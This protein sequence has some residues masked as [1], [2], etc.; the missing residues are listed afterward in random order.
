MRSFLPSPIREAAAALAVPRAG[1]ADSFVLHAPLELLARAGLLV[2]TSPEDRE[3]AL[4]QVRRLGTRFEAAGDPVEP[5]PRADPDPARLVAALRAGDLDEVDAQ[6]VALAAV[7]TAGELRELLGPV[8]LS[9]LAA[10]AHGAILLHL[11]RTVD[12]VGALPLQLIRQP[13]RELARNPTWQLRWF[14]DPDEPSVTR[15]LAE[16]LLDVPRL[17]L[18]GSDFIHPL[19]RQAEDSGVAPAL[20]RGV[21]SEAPA[22]E[23]DLARVAAWSMLQE[24]DEHV[25]YGW[26]HCL[27]MPQAAVRLADVDTRAVAVAATYVVGFRAGEGQ[28]DLDPAAVPPAPISAAELAGYAGSHE[29]AHLAK[30]ALASL[31]AAA[32]D[33]EMRHLHLAAA[34]RLVAWWRTR[35]QGPST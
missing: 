8:V 34:G 29:D 23:R 30:Y 2:H 9:S 21:R 12:P 3:A 31:Q 18:P 32:H 1:P 35:G 7:A 4:E 24:P 28:I 22:A 15:A 13:L 6:A 14:D 5:P 26:T 11:Q 16:V 10:A 25:P 27:T 17:G 19:M 33:P 20:L